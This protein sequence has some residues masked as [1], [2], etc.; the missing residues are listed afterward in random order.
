MQK[1][2]SGSGI[3]Q[4][5]LVPFSEKKDYL[6]AW[7]LAQERGMPLASISLYD[8]RMAD[9]GD[10]KP[11]GE[12]LA[13]AAQPAAPKMKLEPGTPGYLEAWRRAKDE[14]E[15]ALKEP[16]NPAAQRAEPCKC[17]LQTAA[18]EGKVTMIKPAPS[19]MAWVKG[20]L[21]YPEKGGVFVPG[22]DVVDSGDSRWILPA[23]Y[24]PPEALGRPGIALFMDSVHLEAEYKE[25]E[26]QK[27]E[28]VE[29][30]RPEAEKKLVL[31][32]VTI[33]PSSANPVRMLSPFIQERRAFGIV[34][35]ETMIPLANLPQDE[36][37]SW[38]PPEQ[39]GEIRQLWRSEGVGVRPLARSSY[40]PY[41][42][43]ASCWPGNKFGVAL[44]ALSITA[45]DKAISVLPE[46]AITAAASVSR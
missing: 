20:I 27:P 8:C 25:F 30:A 35:E 24:V 12:R 43:Y 22:R 39:G 10:L 7:K 32:R 3:T 6:G 16:S 42:V 34:D 45:M 38:I 21:V 41:S 23:N 5:V 2:C 44:E 28:P 4:K 46:S 9:A 19:G 29:S 1:T 40:A 14:M 13:G 33:M 26:G 11:A 17:A 37:S 31:V 36:S 18:V 15:K